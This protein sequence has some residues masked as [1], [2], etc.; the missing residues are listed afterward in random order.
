MFKLSCS[1]VLIYYYPPLIN[2]FNNIINIFNTSFK[3][4]VFSYNSVKNIYHQKNCSGFQ[5][6]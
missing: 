4:L 6:L 2:T 3:E 5:Q 1:K